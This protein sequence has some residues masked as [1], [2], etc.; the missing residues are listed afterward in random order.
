V[1]LTILATTAAV[2]GVLMGAAPL[3]QARRILRVQSSRDVSIGFFCVPVAGQFIWVV[4]GIA[5]GNT[6]IIASNGC[7]CLCNALVI[8]VALAIR[9]R[10]RPEPAR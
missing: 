3:L 5:L 4:Y 1:T 2:F 9:A 10:V 8:A 7:G 6:A